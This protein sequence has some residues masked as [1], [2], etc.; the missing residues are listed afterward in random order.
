MSRFGDA[1]TSNRAIK[2]ILPVCICQKV[3]QYT[4]FLSIF[5]VGSV[6]KN[7]QKLCYHKAINRTK[8]RAE[9]WTV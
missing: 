5:L 4:A 6:L 9:R 3:Y 7:V 8:G 2:I 1:P